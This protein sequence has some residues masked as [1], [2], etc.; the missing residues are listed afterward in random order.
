MVFILFGFTAFSQ[1][2]VEITSTEPNPTNS[3]PFSVT[4]EFSEAVTGFDVEDI[5]ITSGTATNFNGDFN[6]FFT[7]DITPD[8]DDEITVE[9][10]ADVCYDEATELTSNDASNV[11]MITYDGT[12]PE[13]Y[14]VSFNDPIIDAN[15]EF[16][17]SFTI[18][19]AEIDAE[20]QYSISSS[21]GGDV[22]YGNGVI[23]NTDEIV[24]GVDVSGLSDGELTIGLFLADA[25]GNNGIVVHSSVNKQTEDPFYLVTFNVDMT[26]AVGFDPEND[27]VYITGSMLGWAEPGTDPDNQT[28]QRI[29]ETMMWTVS[30]E[31]TPG[32]YDYKYFLNAGWPGGEWGGN[33]NREIEVT[34]DADIYDTWSYLN[35]VY[36]VTD[37][38]GNAYPT[39][40]IGNQEWFASNLRT[41]KYAD[42][43]DIATNLNNTDWENADYGAYAI[44]PYTDIDG[45]NSDAE[46]LEAYG[47]LY[48]WYAVD[49]PRGLCPDGWHVPNNTEWAV[50]A[51]YLGGEEIAGGFLKSTRTVPD[52]HPRWNSPNTDAVDIYGFS[53]LPG[54]ARDDGG[55]FIDIGDIC[56]FWTA[57][58]E[59]VNYSWLKYMQYNYGGIVNAASDINDGLSIRCIRNTEPEENIPIVNTL[60]P[61]NITHSSA[62]SGG[63]V[64][65]EGYA[66][67][68]D[69]GVV[70]TSAT[71][72][73]YNIPFEYI[74][75][76]PLLPDDING[77]SNENNELL[78]GTII[79]YKTK[80]ER[81]GK[82]MVVSHGDDL[83]IKWITYDYSGNEHSFGDNLTIHSSWHA[84][85]DAGIE[86]I[87]I[88]D[89]HWSNQDGTIRYLMPQNN[90]LFGIYTG[91]GDVLNLY[92]A[93]G[94]TNE[95]SGIGYFESTIGD[96]SPNTQFYA[97]AY[98][99]NIYGT[100]YGQ[101]TMFETLP[102][103]SPYENLARGGPSETN[104]LAIPVQITGVNT[105]P[106][107]SD[108]NAWYGGWLAPQ[109]IFDQG[110][111]VNDP[112]NW[113]NIQ[114]NDNGGS[115]WNNPS[116]GESYGVLVV[117]LQQERNIQWVSV[118]QMFSDGKTTHIALAAHPEIGATA[119]DAL[120]GDWYEFLEKSQVNYGTN[121]TT[122]ITDPSHFFANVNTRYVKIMAYNDGSHGD[123]DYIELKGIKM[124]EES[125]PSHSVTFNVDMTGAINF[126]PD[127]DFVY[128]TG[129]MFGW[130]WPAPGEDPDNQMMSRIEESMIW[131]K[132]LELTEGYYEYKFF[133]NEGWE[134]GEWDGNPNRELNVYETLVI[135]NIW[136]SLYPGYFAGGS[137]NESEP[138]LVETA[139]HLNN[140]R[141]FPNA[142]FM[143]I[144]NIDL[145]IAPF[146][147][148][149]GWEPIGSDY[150]YFLGVY[151]GNGFTISGLYINRENYYQGLFGYM[152]NAYVHNVTLEGADISGFTSVGGIAGYGDHSIIRDCHVSGSIS[153][154][155]WIGGIVGRNT[156]TTSNVR[157]CIS[158]A[159]IIATG[160]YIGGLVGFS[161]YNATV[162]TSY[163]IG[164]VTG[165]YAV[166]G[167]VGWNG[168]GASIINSFAKGNVTGVDEVGG[169]VGHNDGSIEFTY[170]TGFIAGNSNLGG[171][172]G[173]NTG[174]VSSSYWNTQT[175]G[176]SSSNGGEGRSTDDMQYPY[177]ANTYVDWNFSSIWAEDI[178]HEVN[179]GY[180][181]LTMT[182]TTPTVTFNVDMSLAYDFNPDYDIVFITGSMLGWAEPGIDPDN[183]IMERIGE[184]MIWTKTFELEE[185]EYI[186][187]YFINPNWSPGDPAGDRYITVSDDMVLNDT[188]GQ[189]GNFYYL[190]LQS[191]PWEGGELFGEGNYEAW[192]YPTVSTLPNFGYEFINW[193]D[194]LAEVVSDNPSFTYYM[195][196]HNVTLTA[197]FAALP[198]HNL[199]FTVTNDKA[200]PLEN[201]NIALR[202]Q[203]ND[204]SGKAEKGDITQ[205][206]NQKNHYISLLKPMDSKSERVSGAKHKEMYSQAESIDIDVIPDGVQTAANHKIQVTSNDPIN[207]KDKSCGFS[208]ELFVG[209]YRY[210]SNGQPEYVLNVEYLAGLPTDYGF[211]MPAGSTS[212]SLFGLV[213]HDAFMQ[214]SQTLAWVN[215]QNNLVYIPYQIIYP[216]W[217]PFY[218]SIWI[219]GYYYDSWVNSCTMEFYYLAYISLPES[220]YAF[221]AYEFFYSPH[222]LIDLITD[223]NGQASAITIDGN[224][225]YTV[226]TSGYFPETGNVNL[227][228]DIEIP[229]TLSGIFDGGIGTEE[230]PYLISNATQ[231][232]AISEYI[233]YEY[234]G[235][236][237][238]QVADIDLGQA[239]W[240]ENEGWNP[241]GT[242][243]NPFCGNYDGYGH[244]IQNLT[245]NR[246]NIQYI[247]LFGYANQATI[248]NLNLE[249]VN[250]LGMQR[251]GALVGRIDNGYI[252]NCSSSGY[253]KGGNFT[254]GLVGNLYYNSSMDYCH[255]NADIDVTEGVFQQH[256][257]LVGR[258][259]EGGHVSNSFATGNV[260]GYQWVG[261]L[262]GL[263]STFEVPN[264][265]T[266]CYATGN[267]SGVLNVGGLVS[268]LDL[269]DL[270]NAYS[271]GKVNGNNTGGLVG[272][273]YDE[274]SSATSSYWNIET[275]QQATSAA[276]TPKYTSELVSQATFTGWD[277]EELWS[278]QE[279]ETYPY[280]Q[281]QGEAGEFNYPIALIPPSGLMAL[282]GDESISLI[283]QAPSMGSP[284]GYKIYRDGLLIQ[285]VGSSTLSYVDEGL[286]NFTYYT[287]HVTALYGAEESMA[288]IS[289]TTFPNPGFSGGDGTPGNP[290]QVS[291]AEELYTVRLFMSSYFIQTADIDLGVAPWNA[292]E[293]WDPICDP[294]NPFKGTYNGDSHTVSNIYINTPTRDHVALF[295]Y[296]NGGIINNLGVLNVNIKGKY[297]VAGLVGTNHNGYIHDCFAMGVLTGDADVAGIAGWNN[298]GTVE[299][300]FSSV[301]I[302][303]QEG[304]YSNGG[305][306]GLNYNNAIVSECYSMGSIS[307][308]YSGGI[309]GWNFTGTVSNSYSVANVFG[310]NL[311]GGLVGNQS[312]SGIIYNSYSSGFVSAGA[313][314]TG[315]LVGMGQVDDVSDSYWNISTSGQTYSSG[316]EGLFT[317]DMLSQASFPA[318]DFATVW[319]IV[320]GESYP[321][322]KWQGTPGEH[323]YP[324]DELIDID[325]N[326]Y[327]TVII[328]EQEWMAENLRVTRFQNG[329]LIQNGQ[330]LGTD[331]PD[332]Y[333]YFTYDNNPANINPYGLLYTG[334][335]ILD[336]RE[337]CPVGWTVPTN[338][339]WKVMEMELGMSWE[340]ASTWGMAN[341]HGTN[342]G[343]KLKSTGYLH[344][345][346]PNVGATNEVG[347]NALP[348]GGRS[349]IFT[350]LGQTARF[351]S[352][353]PVNET[354]PIIRL[355]S[356]NHPRTF[357]SY[358]QAGMSSSIRCIKVQYDQTTPQVATGNITSVE[359]TSAT[360]QAEVLD[361]GG[362]T[363]VARGIAYSR[364]N[365]E[366]V[367]DT[368]FSDMF[369]S[370][371]TGMGTFTATVE[372]LLPGIM[373]YARAYAVNANGISYGDIVAFE[374]PWADLPS[375][376]NTIVQNKT[377]TTIS[378]SSEVLNDG[379]FEV[380]SRG[381]TWST[382]EY[383]INFENAI[384]VGSGI[385]SFTAT[386]DGLEPNTLYFIRAFATNANGTVYSN[387]VF[388]ST[389]SN[390]PLPTLD[391]PI[392]E[393]IGT[394][395]ATLRANIISN[396]GLS[397][398]DKGFAISWNGGNEEIS[399]GAGWT[400]MLF[401]LNDLTPGTEYNVQAYAINAN[402]KIY[403]PSTTFYTRFES[404]DQVLSFLNDNIYYLMHAA[405]IGVG[406]HSDFGMKSLDI[407][408]DLMAND[409]V[410]HSASY[411][412]FVFNYQ[413]LA[414]TNKNNNTVKDTWS[415]L[416]L[417]ID[418]IN[419]LIDNIEYA[420]GNQSDKNNILAQVLALRAYAHFQLVQ[421][422]SHAYSFDPSA[423]GIPYITNGTKGTYTFSPEQR[424][425][426]LEATMNTLAKSIEE[427]EKVYK[428]GDDKSSKGVLQRG[429]VADVFDLLQIDLDAAIDLFQGS[430]PHT[431]PLHIDLAVAHGLRAKVALV[432][433]DWETAS[434][435]AN[436]AISTAESN[437][438]A[439]YTPAGYNANGFNSVYGSEWMWGSQITE[440]NSTIYAS[441]FSHMDATVMSY[442]QLG[443]QKKITD[444]LYSQFPETDVRKALFIAPG[445]GYNQLVDYTQMKF[446]D[447]G[448]FTGDYIYMRLSEMYL[449]KAE[450]LAHQ[451]GMAS[452]A[453]GTLYN[454][455]SQRDPAYSQS[456]NTGQ[457][458]VN[459]I[460]LH[461]RMEL[462]GEGHGFTDIKRLQQPLNRPEGWGNHDPGFAMAMYIPAN[463]ESF[464]W[465][466][467]FH[468]YLD[469]AIEGVGEVEVE[470]E[471]FT[472]TL[473][474]ADNALIMLRATPSS[475]FISWTINGDVVSNEPEFL[476]QMP[477]VD[478]TVTANFIGGGTSLYPVILIS[479]PVDG[480]TLT[481]NGNYAEGQLVTI[482]ATPNDGY[483]FEN[484]MHEGDE[485][486]TSANFSF[487]MP[488]EEVTLTANFIVGD[489]YTLTLIVE[490]EGTGFVMGAG[491]YPAQEDV[492]ISATPIDGYTFIDWRI[493]D[494]TISTDPVYIFTMPEN[495][496]TIVAHFEEEQVPILQI[497]PLLS[498]WNIFSLY[499]TPNSLDLLDIVQPLINNSQLVK[500]QDQAGNAIEYIGEQWINDIGNV[501]LGQ[502]YKIRLNQ[503][504]NL[505]LIGP[506]ANGNATWNYYTGWNIGGYPLNYPTNALE[507]SQEIIND[508]VLQKIQS[509]T[510]AAI[511]FLPGFGW[512]N[513]IGNF[514]PGQGY[515]VRVNADYSINKKDAEIE[516]T[517]PKRYDG[518][519][520]TPSWEGFGFDHHN[521][522]IANA[523]LNGEALPAGTQIGVFDG[524]LCVGILIVDV[525]TTTP[526]RLVATQNDPLTTSIDGFTTGNSMK[527]M[528][529]DNRNGTFASELEV[530]AHEGYTTLFQTSGTS[531]VD[532]KATSA[533]TD[534]IT[535]SD[536]SYLGN[537]FPNPL[538][539]RTSIS[540]YLSNEE[541]INISIYN[542]LGQKVSV[543]VE[544]K[545][546]EG[547]HQIEWNPKKYNVPQGIYVVRMETK[548][549]IQSKRIVFNR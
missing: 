429:T 387:R 103:E 164:N 191:N 274:T 522:Y 296:V 189:G 263:S 166:G 305:I 311:I 46:V 187:K 499:V 168:G 422:F 363:V 430:G 49:D 509:Q 327:S 485:V 149:E 501:D 55:S 365:S 411:G 436:M 337:V 61:F 60:E 486:S 359:P 41:N 51:D 9:V 137:G 323:N 426:E 147:L 349:N 354:Q 254:A 56:Y 113:S 79:L 162:K 326:T 48:N 525:N 75:N 253:L 38:E 24:S 196:D 379:G 301:S 195:P 424:E 127:N 417:M 204:K 180:P 157:N 213:I 540:F 295:G 484:W 248:T 335:V 118:F 306:V 101:E 344:W 67:V 37:A 88:S 380:L 464:N 407:I 272:V 183:Q 351:F 451:T 279:G 435:H 463:N 310:S 90:A 78:P 58:E 347:F 13:G 186:Y 138:F 514:I 491:S 282:T 444:E 271:T 7:V 483:I 10:Q 8:F 507:A 440:E 298:N 442:A 203:G 506:Y 227:S 355:Y 221:G 220:G 126:D 218:G 410:L 427:Y 205:D 43:S 527:F 115:T 404:T 224:Y 182:F 360:I 62:T 314:Q 133:M 539:D 76:F 100:G 384:S 214:G 516:S 97:K 40:T 338:E 490:P 134:N 154:S 211:D 334:Y 546:S 83:T 31:L 206:E 322:L 331:I 352:S 428:E 488:A 371:G 193:T 474:V 420:S 343:G 413:H 70:W 77:S 1:L 210:Y 452:F 251:I 370:N 102:E 17:C 468:S 119:P 275:S 328:G 353:T 534:V 372:G 188:W 460:L 366:P 302:M 21:G 267:V 277:F 212:E 473:L 18:Y 461:R 537:I 236:H 285:N 467:P 16:S 23:D 471:L 406:N 244:T 536:G 269:T 478:V 19:N 270:S 64:V 400:A 350:E 175:S 361:N 418:R 177:D 117:D 373:Y 106:Y 548:G 112:F 346:M 265:I 249:N 547:L 403:G 511:E 144:A 457:N 29:G 495:D 446:L 530:K 532:L 27:V 150:N 198:T 14:T 469:I 480:G 502:G 519:V 230:E 155:D 239:P 246:P 226:K 434:N 526:M 124:F 94:I 342:E 476:F 73:F 252:T 86:T 438:K 392:V 332:S 497:I 377:Q 456:T 358:T 167:L 477:T 84:D 453:Q 316:G 381:F 209:Q 286:D 107:T 315:G 382:S 172:I 5:I 178:D 300:C 95:G 517:S 433:E 340:V 140:V 170:S 489:T 494:V 81:Y 544:G 200:E 257:G 123:S 148:N 458:L 207:T 44:Y 503:N 466:I 22:V 109:A 228:N 412:W 399:L 524:D 80:E 92:N 11:F 472:S 6:P 431:N 535:I 333:Y 401:Q 324:T 437:G 523:T 163:A 125:L 57:T 508:G 232:N 238:R 96:L 329:D 130:P 292:G 374:T 454:L 455:I 283:W 496:V 185:G 465:R 25:A 541:D 383:P 222:G 549:L 15:N 53:A 216:N 45:L 176:Q 208:H 356:Y 320:E 28:M 152:S 318:W 542:L 345:A 394:T 36:Y 104:P 390:V 91:Q 531:V 425:I 116:P 402:G 52:N 518:S 388:T 132:T 12:A 235:V 194:E 190:S 475:E 364:Y 98:A 415:R 336:E 307:G 362:A 139:E 538:H 513:S 500:V 291:N 505:T 108:L 256:G 398:L 165:D 492:T 493:D 114:G 408:N 159:N 397:I 280:F 459:E 386:I 304:S 105:T 325:G 258:L 131:T 158:N 449:I 42:G 290:F 201:V 447:P 309:V 487:T 121:N 482:S 241:I 2:T 391:A 308:D 34:W 47:A 312:N 303:P 225:Y 462:W 529:W 288:S 481:G 30:L 184:S 72:L 240:N 378:V 276:G 281:Y 89:F 543:L 313:F 142:Q 32:I 65:D 515:R 348:G 181:Y 243:A 143:Q 317:E 54:G 299:R 409:M 234:L 273:F 432:M 141:Y 39:V 521:I 20:Y 528:L 156:G 233:G 82:F 470:G 146:N 260:I 169:L 268:E 59:D 504:A 153:G 450:A 68:T 369:T 259:F 416:Y 93:S 202:Y 357:R 110:E 533:A 448:G 510:G 66:E 287:Y 217:D 284:T 122:Y 262:I 414:H 160:Q 174:L 376:S 367:P 545:L 423:P 441:F 375:I 173:I 4:I 294:N 479:N 231:L 35:G 136:G 171:L 197:N 319:S 368:Q 289:A 87:E 199:T 129:S 445:T 161:D 69:R 385:G 179:D 3:N 128:L 120:D 50:L 293:G 135:D 229:V 33:P 321:Y 242:S 266:N 26:D 255:S 261:G 99:T 74:Q 111:F 396:G 247:G 389:N 63:D 219:E 405:F 264:S 85:L 520:F 341:G 330:Y 215:T 151:N 245:I 439:L 297:E 421:V 395:T 443:L 192:S 237:F 71:N 278:I 512:I 419:F 223:M 145:A 393:D 339:Q 250:I 498:G